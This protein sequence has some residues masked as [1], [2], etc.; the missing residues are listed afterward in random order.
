M[1]G[2]R[3]FRKCILRSLLEADGVFPMRKKAPALRFRKYNKKIGGTTEGKTN[4][5]NNDGCGRCRAC[6]LGEWMR[7]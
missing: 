2:Y 6:E 3:E 4:E 1:F 5:Q 7:F